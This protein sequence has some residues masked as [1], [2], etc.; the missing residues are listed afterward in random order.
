MWNFQLHIPDV[1]TMNLENATVQD[2][3]MK[4]P[5][6]TYAQ[7]Q[8]EEVHDTMKAHGMGHNTWSEIGPKLK[9]M[10]LKVFNGKMH[11]LIDQ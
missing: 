5:V 7:V 11:E 8:F 6:D 9:L 10:M 4:R 2:A 1:V 3:E